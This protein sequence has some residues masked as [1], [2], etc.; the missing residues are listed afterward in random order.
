[1]PT[2]EGLFACRCILFV[3]DEFFLA[4]DLRQNLH[5]HHAEI[6]G[7]AGRSP[8][9]GDDWRSDRWTEWKQAS[10]R[11]Q[12][13]PSGGLCLSSYFLVIQ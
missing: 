5:E 10:N 4:D 9:S 12:R 13:P 2:G 1:M 11:K 3:D 8:T 7:P 6:F